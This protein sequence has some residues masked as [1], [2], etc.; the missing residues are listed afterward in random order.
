MTKNLMELLNL[1]KE[2]KV[3]H[4]VVKSSFVNLLARGFR[5]IKNV[6]I[7]VLLGFSYQTDAF[8]MAL[9]LLGRG[10]QL[11]TSRSV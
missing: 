8:F 6:A 10:C 4:A 11:L 9:S 7:A 5:Y 2:E 3:F 1:S